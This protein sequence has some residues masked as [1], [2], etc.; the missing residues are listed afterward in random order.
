MPRRLF[1]RMTD[2]LPPAIDRITSNP[3]VLRC[4][5]AL[6]YPDLRHRRRTRLRAVARRP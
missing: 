6:A 5:P 3:A 4:F 2:R 1:A